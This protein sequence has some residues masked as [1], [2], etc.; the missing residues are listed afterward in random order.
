LEH[1][2]DAGRLYVRSSLTSATGANVCLTTPVRASATPAAEPRSSGQNVT[3]WLVVVLVA[4]AVPGLLL[5]AVALIAAKSP[6]WL[7]KMKRGADTGGELCK[8]RPG[9]DFRARLEAIE[10]ALCRDGG[11]ASWGEVFHQQWRRPLMI[12]IGLAI[13][14]IT[15]I[16]A[17]IYYADRIFGATG[18]VT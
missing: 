10:T 14:Q 15:G 13:L 6:S 12:G 16:N 9:V 8:V 3:P 2:K 1:G 18:I 7:M 4:S 11:R 17:I 5:F